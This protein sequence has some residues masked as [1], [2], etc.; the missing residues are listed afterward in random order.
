MAGVLEQTPR[1]SG[2]QLAQGLPAFMQEQFLQVPEVAAAARHG[3][4][5]ISWHFACRNI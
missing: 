5:L 2:R 3:N 4:V 1:R